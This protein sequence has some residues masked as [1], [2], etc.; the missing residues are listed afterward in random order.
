[1]RFFMAVSYQKG[2]VIIRAK[3]KADAIEYLTN[4]D[5]DVYTIDSLNKFCNDIYGD[6]VTI[7]LDL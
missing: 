7:S 4:N 5:L 1:M 2:N 3:N 6:D